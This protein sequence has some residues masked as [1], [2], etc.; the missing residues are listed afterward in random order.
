MSYAVTRLYHS[1]QWAPDL[2]EATKFFGQVF[3]RRSL[4]M[5][6]LRAL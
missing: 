5:V 1:T 3:G 2:S 4:D 6:E